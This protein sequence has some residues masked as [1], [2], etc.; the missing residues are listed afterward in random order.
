MIQQSENHNPIMKLRLVGQF[1]GLICLT[2]FLAYIVLQN[3]S[4]FGATIH[5]SSAVNKDKSLLVPGPRERVSMEKTDQGVIFKQTHDL[6]YFTTKMP[7][8]F[9]EA[10]V[11]LTYQNTHPEQIVFVGFQDQPTWHYEKKLFDVPFLNNLNWETMGKNPTLYQREKEFSSIEDFLAY[12][13]R[14][15]LIGTYEYDIDIGTTQKTKLL[16]YQTQATD[17]KIDVPLRGKHILYAYLEN[18]PFTISIKKQDLNWYE[19]PDPMT[20]IIYKDGQVVYKTIIED[21]GITDA[22]KK[23]QSP[24]QT[25][26]THPGPG[27]PEN[28]VYKIVLDANNDTIINHITTNLHK[29][30]FAGSIFPAANHDVYPEVFPQTTGTTLYTNALMLSATTYHNASMQDVFVG[31]KR[32]RLNTKDDEQMITP[33]AD[34]TQVKTTKNDVIL[35]TFEGYSAFSPRQFFIPMNYHV[36][37]I[38]KKSDT[39]LSDFIL[40]DYKPG[41]NRNGW[42]TSKRTFDLSNAYVKNGQLTWVIMAPK[43]QEHKSEIQIGNIQVTL[44]KKPW[45]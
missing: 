11:S 41:E 12:P 14:Q 4:P 34:F 2:G 24:Q 39:S 1:L 44:D 32:I 17:T 37:P 28:G 10:T 30:V 16:N 23:I 8:R 3:L 43:L 40:T 31:N 27:L 5:Y 35:N 18:E 19:D 13:P 15:A 7:L 42:R 22:S 33:D 6:I 21:D 9:D 25:T 20:I 26:I 45:F 38:T 29:L 36:F